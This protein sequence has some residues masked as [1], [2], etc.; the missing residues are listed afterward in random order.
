MSG[1]SADGIDAALVRIG[2]EPRELETLAFHCAALPAELR[3]RVQA[4]STGRIALREL[5]ALDRELGLRFADAALELLR[6]AGV[7]AD[8][9]EGIGS[10]GQTVAHHPEPGVC[11]SL[12]IGSP[13]LIHAR[14]GIPVVANFRAADLAVGGQGAPLTPFVHLACLADPRETRAVLN[15]GGFSNVTFLP[16]T[17]PERVVAFDPGPANALIDRAARWAS[18]GVEAF[19]RDGARARRG[20]VE[21]AVLERLL[22]DEYF[23]RRPPKSTGHE[24]F[25]AAFFERA[26]DA[27]LASGGSAD[28]VVATL[29]ALTVES[30]ARGARDFFPSA[31]Q[32][33]LLC[34]GGVHNPALVDGLRSRLAP[35]LVES[36]A[37]SGVDPDALEAV[38]FAVLGWCAARGRASNL[39]AATGA[40][41]AIPLGSATPAAAFQRPLRA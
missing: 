26:R 4:A 19:D 2:S 12:Q 24:R 1:T 35:A 33:W 39:P 20:R 9:V 15:L 7:S 31:P 17:D 10:H 18:D 36:S 5:L 3:S 23:R 13:A 6:Q 37:A 11:G 34:G 8:A 40:S 14:T 30:V 32:R 28:D 22:D 16:G 38:A 21:G 41:R 25:G 29:T 27:V